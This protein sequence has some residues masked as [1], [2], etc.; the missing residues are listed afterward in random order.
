MAIRFSS[1]NNVKDFGAMGDDTTDDTAAI[2]AA[3]ANAR[4]RMQTLVS[5]TITQ[6]TS[7]IGV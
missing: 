7:S 4:S 2:N 6:G 3:F 5:S 1:A